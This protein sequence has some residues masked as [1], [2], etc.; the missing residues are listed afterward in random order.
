MKEN[1]IPEFTELLTSEGWIEIDKCNFKQPILVIR[2]KKV[3]YLKP[4]IFS[5]YVYKGEL[6]EIETERCSI[7]LKPSTVIIVNEIPTKVDLVRKGDLLDKYFMYQEV[8]TTKKIVWEGKVY[9]IKFEDDTLSFL[10]IKFEQD[11]SLLA[12]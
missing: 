8:V 4:K 10:P 6:I 2:G 9:S 12:V 1:F 7:Y 5:S 11:Y 3:L